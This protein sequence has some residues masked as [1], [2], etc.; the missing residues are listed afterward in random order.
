MMLCDLLKEA[1]ETGDII[2]NG[3]YALGIIHSDK[4]NCFVWCDKETGKAIKRTQDITGYQ[5]V[6]LSMK[7]LE[8]DDW[9]LNPLN[10]NRERDKTKVFLTK[11]G[12]VVDSEDICRIIKGDGFGN[13]ALTEV[14][15]KEGTIV[16]KGNPLMV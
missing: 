9:Y 13:Y 16:Y 15:K 1:K 12:L 4:F 14:N 5:R 7:L 10:R 6:I 8:R 2:V 3:K 11:N